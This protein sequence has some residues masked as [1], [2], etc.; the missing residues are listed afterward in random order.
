M[1]SRI[2]RGFHRLG[3]VLA[4]PL[5]LGAVIPPLAQW[6][7]PDGPPIPDHAANVE[8]P[9]AIR[10]PQPAATD[11]SAYEITIPD[12]R[13]LSVTA[14]VGTDE[15]RL[16]RAIKVL[17]AEERR[18]GRVFDASDMPL[19][20]GEVTIE[21]DKD[22]RMPWQSDHLKSGFDIN[23]WWISAALAGLGIAAYVAARVIG[24]VLDGFFG[25]NDTTA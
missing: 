22:N 25:P 9:V 4:V 19:R 20:I 7:S 12:R 17:H 14:P 15:V 18:R 21:Y 2:V 6:H 11:S 16:G 3:L 1:A 8:E 13:V 10:S 24:W 5:I 23:A